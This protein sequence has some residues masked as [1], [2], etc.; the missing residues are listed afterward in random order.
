[1]SFYKHTEAFRL[2]KGA[3][4][5]D[6]ETRK[7]AAPC[8]TGEEGERMSDNRWAEWAKELQFLSQ[9]ALA[10]C[11][12]RYDIE[13]FE[14]IREIAAEMASE[15]GDLPLD[16]VKAT[17]CA[18]TGYQTP[19]LDTRAAVIRD[20]RI[21]LVRETNGK[22]ALPGGWVDYDHTIRTN[23]VKE[24]LEEAGMVVEPV[25]VIALFDHNRRN[26]TA[27]PSNICSVYV[28]CAY[29]SGSFRPNLET[30]ASGFFDRDSLPEPLETRKTTREQIDL[31]FQ[32]AEDEHWQVV[33]D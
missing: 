21:L 16:R 5:E 26:H 33:F 30:T 23:T 15:L 12:D 20:G 24:V 2:K 25:R 4:S 29:R 1:M 27:Y 8:R 7:D 22:W 14:R 17:F 9:C 13:R 31:C 10:Y 19:K 28:L 32:A 3:A 6:R 18:G 11:T